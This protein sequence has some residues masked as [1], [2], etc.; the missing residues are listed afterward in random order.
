MQYPFVFAGLGGATPVPGADL[1]ANFQAA[2]LANQVLG[3]ARLPLPIADDTDLLTVLRGTTMYTT[4]VS[5]VGAEALA[6][7][8]VAAN[9]ANT[10]AAAADE[11]AALATTAAELA[12]GAL[13]NF[14]AL[15]GPKPDADTLVIAGLLSPGDGRGG[16]F[17]WVS[18]ETTADDGF[19]FAKPSTVSGAGRY[20]RSSYLAYLNLLAEWYVDPATRTLSAAMQDRIYAAFAAQALGAQTPLPGV[21]TTTFTPGQY[22]TDGNAP[23]VLDASWQTVVG[24]GRGSVVTFPIES[25]ARSQTIQDLTSVS[26]VPGEGT[27]LTFVDSID[28]N[29]ISVADAGGGDILITFDDRHHA[30]NIAFGVLTLNASPYVGD[31][32]LTAIPS[33]TTLQV[34]ASFSTTATG[35]AT[36]V[37]ASPNTNGDNSGLIFASW[38]TGF[39]T[40]GRCAFKAFARINSSLNN[41]GYWANHNGELR[42]EN[43]VL[44]GNADVALLNTQGSLIIGLTQIQKTDTS[45]AGLLMYG[46]DDLYGFHPSESYILGVTAALGDS[47]RKLNIVSM[48]AANPATNT[49]TC[50]ARSLAVTITNDVISGRIVVSSYPTKTGVDADLTVDGGSAAPQQVTIASTSSY[51]GD[52]VIQ[53]KIDDYSF[54]IET[55]YTTDQSGTALITLYIQ[56]VIL[57]PGAA[58]GN[59]AYRGYLFKTTGG[60]GA[61]QQSV[62][63]KYTGADKRA[64][65]QTPLTIGTDATTTYEILGTKLTTDTPTLARDLYPWVAGIVAST[66]QDGQVSIAQASGVRSIVVGREFTSDQTGALILQADDVVLVGRDKAMVEQMRFTGGHVS[67]FSAQNCD[68]VDL[69]GVRVKGAIL[70]GEGVTGLTRYGNMRGSFGSDPFRDVPVYFVKGVAKGYGEIGTFNYFNVTSETAYI[71]GGACR[72]FRM[73]HT[74]SGVKGNPIPIVSISDAGGG[75]CL[76]TLESAH[77]SRSSNYPFDV[78]IGGTTNYNGKFEVQEYVDTTTLTIK[79]TFTSSQTGVCTL[80][81]NEAAEWDGNFTNGAQVFDVTAG[82]LWRKT[83]DEGPDA[84]PEQRAPTDGIWT[85]ANT[86]RV[87]ASWNPDGTQVDPDDELQINVESIS[88][89]SSQY[90]IS[91]KRGLMAGYRPRL[92]VRFDGATGTPPS[93]AIFKVITKNLGSIVIQACDG[94]G[95]PYTAGISGQIEIF[96]R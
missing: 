51:N 49:G 81:T 61:G 28:L 4:P 2:V 92:S 21:P 42:L 85:G 71:G 43:S 68:L 55:D 18:T 69:V 70:I 17:T 8:T 67:S 50:Q 96:S 12:Q 77:F 15:Q 72:G 47:N 3:L 31:F 27:G 78:T 93:G 76:I 65:L 20:V 32:A 22:K 29:V 56:Q 24:E 79:A 19:I 89:S 11:A 46:D 10:A 36:L 41:V 86:G 91:F 60:T 14:A 83:S 7:A 48:E 40:H 23:L 35:T 34:T 37:G 82:L 33:P 58:V 13:P 59:D 26:L 73:P 95:A 1:D 5:A 75:L 57:D 87:L 66:D 44:S 88:K 30:Q 64:F 80:N 53:A 25:Y 62:I 52:Y 54:S 84:Q 9:T 63:S 94:S 90:T 74:A 39:A 16:R 38:D 45:A 6:I